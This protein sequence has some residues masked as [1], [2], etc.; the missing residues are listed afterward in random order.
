VIGQADAAFDVL[1]IV[2]RLGTTRDGVL[3]GEIHMVA[4]LAFLLSLYT[5]ETP[6]AWGY[7]FATTPTAAPFSDAIDVAL[8]QLRRVGLVV[9][10]GPTLRETPRTQP[11]LTRW[12]VLSRNVSREPFVRAAVE[13]TAQVSL[14]AMARGLNQEP[15]LR[16]AAQVGG[17]RALPD[18]LA[19]KE[20][21][22]HF[23]SIDRVMGSSPAP[24][25]SGLHDELMVRAALWLDYLNTSVRD[26]A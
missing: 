16:H 23:E 12:A 4:Y 26:V 20:L 18:Y 3:E 7:G 10:H 17:M 21:Q 9:D 14:P 1:T 5:G 25:T 2:A 22:Q 24:M 15:Q 6:E 8:I 13:A 19:L 11:E